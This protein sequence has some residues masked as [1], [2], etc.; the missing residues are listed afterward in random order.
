ML[1]SLGPSASA[2]ESAI[3][4]LDDGD[5]L[6]ECESRVEAAVS[7]CK[8]DLLAWL[9]P[10]I[11]QNGIKYVLGE[12]VVTRSLAATGSTAQQLAASRRERYERWLEDP[13]QWP[14]KARD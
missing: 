4:R 2:C 8:T 12:L 10:K 11:D 3:S 7:A 14:S 13:A 6:E 5:T 1:A 9:P